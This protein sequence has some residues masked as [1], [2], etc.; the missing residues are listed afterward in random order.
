MILWSFHQNMA[1]STASY[2]LAGMQTAM[3]SRVHTAFPPDG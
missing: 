3:E 1:F 2:M